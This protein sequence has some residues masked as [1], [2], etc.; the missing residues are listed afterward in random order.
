MPVIE[1]TEDLAVGVPSIDE[2]HHQFVD[3]LNMLPGASDADF[4]GLFAKLAAHSQEHFAE[5]EQMMERSSFPVID[6]HKAEHARVLA[7][8]EQVQQQ[9]EEGDIAAARIYITDQLSAWFVLHR[10]TMD[11]VTAAHIQRTSGS[12]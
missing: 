9:L 1:W 11:Y 12:Y 7:E 3:L 8:L 2:A 6:I 10:N 4:P 5:E